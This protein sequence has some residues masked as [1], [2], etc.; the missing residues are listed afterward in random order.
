MVAPQAPQ[1]IPEW[2]DVDPA[3]FARDIAT[4]YNR[5]VQAVR[6]DRGHRARVADAERAAACGRALED[7]RGAGRFELGLGVARAHQ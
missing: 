2:R 6:F 1:P 5:F 4:R 7:L 3:T